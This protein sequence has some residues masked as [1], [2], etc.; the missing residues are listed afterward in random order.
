MS[1]ERRSLVPALV[2]ASL[3]VVSLSACLLFVFTYEL[4]RVEN[5]AVEYLALARSVAQGTGFSQDGGLT[6]AVYRPPLFS[7]LL[8]GW[9]RAT[10]TSS[11][12]SVAV[13]QSMLHALGILA[14]FGLFLE[15]LP[16]LAW[17]FCASLFLALNPVLVTRVVFVLQDTTILLFTVVGVWVTVRLIKGPSLVRA[18]LAGTAWGVCT[19]AKIVSWYIPLLLLAMRFLP[20]RLRFTLRGKEA[21]VLLCLFAATIAPWTVRN[22]IHFHRLIPVNGEGEGLLEWNVSHATITGEEPGKRYA[23]EVYRKNLSE[24][25][26][27]ALLWKYVLDH[28]FYFFVHR[29]ARNAIYFAAPPRDWWDYRGYFRSGNHRLNF[30]IPAI[31]FHIPLFLIL[32]IRT[33]QWGRGMMVPAY[34]FIVV[35]YWSYWFEH[36]LLL[37]DFRFGLAVYPLLVA[38]AA[39][40]VR[41]PGHSTAR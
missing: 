21:L 39:P 18:A 10:G 9:F 14:A 29:V 23:T 38:M 4:P 25:D 5:D 40:P 17:A 7:F 11:V 26:R 19:L 8:G 41:L 31:L 36:A 20:R 6:P 27:K 12:L 1:G 34:G 32:L 28:P 16:T 2:S 22:Y 24:K 35:V 37:G 3:V 13:F 15:I 30:W 33:W